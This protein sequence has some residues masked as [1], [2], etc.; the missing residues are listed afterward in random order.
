VSVDRLKKE[1]DIGVRWIA[2]PLHPET[3]EE[4]FTLE[5]LFAGRPVSIG[6]MKTRLRQV[7]QELG[8][9][10][11][12][13]DRT[14]NSRM[15]QELGKWA[16]EQG[17]GDDFHSAVFR[18]YFVDGVNI[19]KVSHLVELADSVGLPAEEARKTLEERAYRQAVDADW[20]RSLAA[21][22]TAVPTFMLQ[23]RTLV[24][25]QPFETL[26]RLMKVGNVRKRAQ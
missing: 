11:G 21:G 8:L 26:E 14:Y 16:E 20:S 12:D 15:A 5:E 4:G 17:R 7:A 19:A 18:A 3:P 6:Q 24:G 13:R 25:M 2:F 10:L 1:Y 22:V 9:P 23:G